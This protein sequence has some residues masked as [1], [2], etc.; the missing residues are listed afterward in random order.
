MVYAMI[1][2]GT[3]FLFF[4]QP[5]F[6]GILRKMSDN[7][8]LNR[9]L[10]LI[11]SLVGASDEAFFDGCAFFRAKVG[12]TYASHSGVSDPRGISGNIKRTWDP[13]KRPGQ[14]SVQKLIPIPWL[15][16]SPPRPCSRADQPS[17]SVA[18]TGEITYRVEL[19]DPPDSRV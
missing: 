3:V 4:L 18:G 11:P 13:N 14:F 5:H 16:S 17:I 2:Q 8:P 10:E 9:S 1:A 19:T 6:C 15:I 7:W 12:T